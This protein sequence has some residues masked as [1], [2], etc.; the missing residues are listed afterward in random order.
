V[1]PSGKY[2]QAHL[3]FAFRS[4]SQLAHVLSLFGPPRPPE[5][6]SNTDFPRIGGMAKRRGGEER[7]DRSGQRKHTENDHVKEMA[8]PQKANWLTWL[9]VTVLVSTCIASRE[10]PSSNLAGVAVADAAG[11][12][13]RHGHH[14]SQHSSAGSSHDASESHASGR[15]DHS[16]HKH[17]GEHYGEH[18]GVHAL[19]DFVQTALAPGSQVLSTLALSY[20]HTQTSL[21]RKHLS[22]SLVFMK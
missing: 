16:S 17:N 18:H 9:L 11:E 20:V 21:M 1:R 12:H 3:D 14:H 19:L 7:T 2:I 5:L 4:S 6:S 8:V 15:G 13:P 10:P 22:A